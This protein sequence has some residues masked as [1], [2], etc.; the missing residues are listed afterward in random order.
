LQDK[1]NNQIKF[2][3]TDEEKE[4]IDAKFLQSGLKSKSQFL[5]KMVLVGEIYKVD[6]KEVKEHSAE[7]GKIGRNVNQLMAKINTLNIIRTE[8]IKKIR[9]L[10]DETYKSEKEF[11]RFILTIIGKGI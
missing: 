3:V 11:I 7:L 5:R 4:I 9:Q 1:K 2:R 10:M 6:L 8:D